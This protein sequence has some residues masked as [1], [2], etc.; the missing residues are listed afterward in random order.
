[1]S[2]NLTHHCLRDAAVK[3]ASLNFGPEISTPH[4]ETQNVNANVVVPNFED[5]GESKWEKRTVGTHGSTGIFCR[6][7]LI[8]S[9][10]AQGNR[11]ILQPLGW[12]QAK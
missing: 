9:I 1:L 4:T 8:G 6:Y 3:N 10:P 12:C 5:L 11:A 7:I 2:W